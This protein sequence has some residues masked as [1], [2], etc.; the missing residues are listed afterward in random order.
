MQKYITIYKTSWQWKRKITWRFTTRHSKSYI[1][2][3]I[4]I[5]LLKNSIFIWYKIRKIK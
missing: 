4:E 5:I 3:G 2:K 1:T